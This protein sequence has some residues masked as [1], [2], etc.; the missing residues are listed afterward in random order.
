MFK[1]IHK[2]NPITNEFQ[3]DSP[4]HAKSNQGNYMGKCN[5]S[6]RRIWKNL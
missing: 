3:Q 1:T 5:K 4:P 6:I 2:R